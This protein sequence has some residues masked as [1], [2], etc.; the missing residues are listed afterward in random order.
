MAEV[1]MT[2]V[3]EMERNIG[4]LLKAV[5]PDAAESIIR[6]ASDLVADEIRRR[7]PVGP[8]GNLKRSIVSKVL[9]RKHSDRSAPAIVAIDYRIGPHAHLVEYG[10]AGP[11]PGSKRTK[12]HPFFRPGWDATKDKAMRLVEEKLKEKIEGAV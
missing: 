9:R 11:K 3:E 10:H 8:K 2:G 1:V 4:K 7:A 12:R 5:G 6:A